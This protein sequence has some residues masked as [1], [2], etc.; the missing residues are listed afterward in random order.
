MSQ[1]KTLHSKNTKTKPA[2]KDNEAENESELTELD[3]P[4]AK[5]GVDLEAALE[6]AA[7]IDEKVEDEILPVGEESEDGSADELTLDDEELNPFGDKWE[8]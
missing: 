8:Q 3:G 1:K 7:I 2:P 5:K 4:K 6:P